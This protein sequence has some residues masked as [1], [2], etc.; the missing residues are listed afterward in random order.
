MKRCHN[1]QAP[2]GEDWR[3]CRH[4]GTPLFVAGADDVPTQ[5][6]EPETAA[7]RAQPTGPAYVGP[8]PG[9]PSFPVPSPRKR[10]RFWIAG[11]V[12]AGLFVMSLGVGAG[13]FWLRERRL[14]RPVF[15]LEPP[16]PLL[17][18]ERLPGNPPVVERRVAFP[19]EGIF[20]LK[21]VNGD[22]EIATW[23]RA[24]AQMTARIEGSLASGTAPPF[25]V[26]SRGR[27]L[28]V[29][30][31]TDEG[32]SP[33]IHYTILLPR[34]AH[35]RRVATVNGNIRIEGIRG[36][37][38]AATVN[39]EIEL[40]K[41]GGDIS[42]EAVNGETRV[43]VAPEA[44][45]KRIAVKTFNGDIRV[46]LPEAVSADFLLQTMHGEIEADPSFP[47]AVTKIPLIGGKKAT[48]KIGDGDASVKIETVNG[49]IMLSR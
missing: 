47:L 11:I 43:D 3:F 41:V 42:T 37:I 20:R 24:E 2:V 6:I 7:Q 26:I 9:V 18:E 29:E 31:Q 21:N 35:L 48:G 28:I 4:C 38:E 40:L 14:H 22:V 49:T 30:T 15:R 45:L 8:E 1:C 36:S 13:L 17:P 27:E 19:R 34:E 23:D 5:V 39:G 46:T 32:V 10:A 12:L 44:S 33:E 16:R 25:S